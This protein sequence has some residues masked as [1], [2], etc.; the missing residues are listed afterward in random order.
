MVVDIRD[1]IT[2][3]KFGNDRLTGLAS[4]EGQILPFPNTTVW[5]YDMLSRAKNEKLIKKKAYMKTET[6][7][8]YSRVFGIY[9]PNVIKID[10]YNFWAIP[11]QIWCIFETQCILPGIFTVA[12]VVDSIVVNVVVVV[13]STV[14]VERTVVSWPAW[15]QYNQ[16]MAL[17]SADIVSFITSIFAV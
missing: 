8:L 12:S 7:R 14:V 2:C 9:L 13:V 16:H 1:I 15:K 3:F 4:A 17:Y 10:H 5:A 11:F 6:C